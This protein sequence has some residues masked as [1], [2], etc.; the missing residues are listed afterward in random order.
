MDIEESR[1]GVA[2]VITPRGRLD[3]HA[4]AAFEQQ[5]L[6]RIA[7]GE[8]TIV[9]DGAH[10][11]YLNSAGL[12]ALLR[13]AKQIDREGGRLVL[14]ALTDNVREVLRLSGLDTVLEIHPDRA[15]ALAA[16]G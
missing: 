13:A 10:L 1:H 4:A 11:D 3:V 15:A 5:L 14:A 16:C 2:L 6:E 8:R 7:A 9:L 12:R